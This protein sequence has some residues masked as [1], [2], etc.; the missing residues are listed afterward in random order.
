MPTKSTCA[1]SSMLRIVFLLHSDL[2]LPDAK[3]RGLEFLTEHV[4]KKPVH[5]SPIHPVA[6]AL[7]ASELPSGLFEHP[8]TRTVGFGNKSMQNVEF[9]IDESMF[10]HGIKDPDAVALAS[11][12]F[13]A[14]DNPEVCCFADP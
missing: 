4:E 9:Q 8:P 14:N 12:C 2:A 11:V 10:H 5:Q 1:R 6:A 7:P 3:I 13:A